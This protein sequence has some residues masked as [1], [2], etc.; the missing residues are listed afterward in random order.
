MNTTFKQ[1]ESNTTPSSQARTT[2][3]LTSNG[4][5]SQCDWVS[6]IYTMRREWLAI[7]GGYAIDGRLSYKG[8]FPKDGLGE[9]NTLIASIIAN[10][11]NSSAE[12]HQSMTAWAFYC[13]YKQDEKSCISMVQDIKEQFI[14]LLDLSQVDWNTYCLAY[15]LATLVAFLELAG[16]LGVTIWPSGH[17]I[18]AGQEW[19]ESNYN[20][21]IT[22][23]C[24]AKP[25]Q[26]L[27]E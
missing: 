26:S 18:K 19:F 22:D 6:E 4:E 27:G 15:K 8:S 23:E 5:V 10:V 9:G 2:D 3:Y 12:L 7:D 24:N 1:I 20:Q 14:L 21:S 17:V 13:A 11:L 25:P 16:C